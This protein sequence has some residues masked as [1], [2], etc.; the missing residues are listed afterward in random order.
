MSVVEAKT[1]VTLDEHIVEVISDSGE[2]AQRCGQSLG[3]IAAK[4]GNGIWT[5]E[6]FERGPSVASWSV[7]RDELEGFVA[8]F[9]GC[10]AHGSDAAHVDLV[11]DDAGLQWRGFLDEHGVA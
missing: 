10:F 9:R 5:V 3:A 2:G 4:M 1:A 8:A 6:I 11:V 7:D